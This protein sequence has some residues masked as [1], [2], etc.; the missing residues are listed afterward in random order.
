[1]RGLIRL[2]LT[3]FLLIYGEDEIKNIMLG[4]LDL[5]KTMSKISNHTF[6]KL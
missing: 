2:Q 5:Y 3:S 4:S 1:M 6:R